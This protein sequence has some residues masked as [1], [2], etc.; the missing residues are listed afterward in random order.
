MNN[1][2]RGY[3]RDRR[4]VELVEKCGALSTGQVAVMLF[5][6]MRAGYRK[7]Q[8]RLQMLVKRKQLMR[9]RPAINVPYVYF[10]GRQ[11]DQIDHRVALNW[12]LI[13]LMKTMA[14]WERTV[15]WE[16][17][18]DYGYIRPD[19]LWVAENMVTGRYRAVYVEL[20]RSIRNRWDK[21]AKYNDLFE[22]ESYAGS[23]WVDKAE[24]FP[25]ILVATTTEARVR[26]IQRTIERDNRHDLRFDVRLLC[27]LKKEV[28]PWAQV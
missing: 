7:A 13:W 3:F 19:L 14:N 15:D 28:W 1:V 22:R 18:P 24:R 21:V 10:V 23:W 16:Y 9:I 27:E 11:M 2:Q 6:H 8:E 4:I 26:Q 25:R 17:E 12:A 5:G 20:D